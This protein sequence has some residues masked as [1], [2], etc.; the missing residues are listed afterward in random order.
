M[1]IIK[2]AERSVTLVLAREV[3]IP[4]DEDVDTEESE[5]SATLTPRSQLEIGTLDSLNHIISNQIC[6]YLSS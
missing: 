5:S 6:C 4:I 2:S 3:E 1:N